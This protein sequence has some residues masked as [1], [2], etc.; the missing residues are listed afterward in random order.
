MTEV[1]FRLHGSPI[2]RTH[3]QAAD[4]GVTVFEATTDLPVTRYRHLQP[5]PQRLDWLP[6]TWERGAA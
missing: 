5:P 4:D 1:P 3:A 6:G 2:P